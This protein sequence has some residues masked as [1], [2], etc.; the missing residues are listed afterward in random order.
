MTRFSNEIHE[1]FKRSDAVRAEEE[2][3]K[4]KEAKEQLAKAITELVSV[5]Q[6]A[7]ARVEASQPGGAR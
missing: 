3:A 5:V 6:S 4:E 1:S 7:Q 2:A